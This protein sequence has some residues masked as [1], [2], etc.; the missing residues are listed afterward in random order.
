MNLSPERFLRFV[1][2]PHRQDAD[3]TSWS[4]TLPVGRW[5]HLAVVNDGRR[6]IV[7]VDG[8]KIPRNPTR[9]ST[10][11]ATLGKPFVI[12]DHAVR[13]EV[14]AGLQRLD[15]RHPHRGRGAV[16]AGLPHPRRPLTGRGPA[17][18]GGGRG[19]RSGAFPARSP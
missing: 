4:H 6:T 1:V 16:P 8:S 15:R 14:R 13:R 12:G 7:Y 17:A 11:I 19:S 10:G 3:P 5:M 18:P 9:R 2:Y